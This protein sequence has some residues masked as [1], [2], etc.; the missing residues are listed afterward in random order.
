MKKKYFRK[1]FFDSIRILV[2]T[3]LISSFGGSAL[4]NVSGKLVVILPLIIM[5]PAMNDMAGNFGSIISSKFTTLLYLGLISH[6]NLFKSRRLKVLFLRM[7]TVSLFSAVYISTISCAL[8]FIRGYEFDFVILIKVFITACVSAVSLVTIISFIA[9]QVGLLIYRKGHD[10]DN[11]LIP[12]TTAVG[13]LGNMI[14]LSLM[15]NLLF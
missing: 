12:I 5:L 6:R 8:S 13:D 10:P 9:V 14:I 4:Q 7:F 2:L 3:S 15:V 1:V 11:F